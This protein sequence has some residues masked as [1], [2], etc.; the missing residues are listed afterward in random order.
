M[1]SDTSINAALAIRALAFVGDLSMGQPT[2]H[3]LRVAWLASR[4]AECLGASA[5]I[6]V[7]VQQAALLRWSGCTANAPEFSG[8]IDDDVSGRAMI[9]AGDSADIRFQF[10]DSQ[11]RSALQTLAQ[12][13]C[14]VSGEVAGMLSLAGSVERTLRLIFEKF[15]GSGPNRLSGDEVPVDVLIL[16]LASDFEVISRIHGLTRAMSFVRSRGEEA[17]PIRLIRFVIDHGDDW[18][19]TLNRDDEWK[20]DLAAL[21]E[22]GMTRAPLE[23]VADVID[24]KLPWMRGYSRRVS[25]TA[26]QVSALMGMTSSGQALCSRAALIHCMGRAAVPNSVWNIPG[27]LP[28]SAREQIRLTPYWVSRAA[29]QIESLAGEATVASYVSERMDGSGSFRGCKGDRIPIEGQVIAASAAW[30]A[31]NSARPWRAA[32]PVETAKTTLL[33]EAAEGRFNLEVANIL[34]GSSIAAQRPVRAAASVLSEREVQVLQAI[35]LGQT[36]KEVARSLEISPST[37]RTHVESVFRKLG[38]TTRAAATLKA[39]ALGLLNY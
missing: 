10:I 4:I 37:V 14:E 29:S 21:S 24:L 20:S 12:I 34:C 30:V 38:C 32:L 22:G 9:L 16:G 31:L 6:R 36:N 15:D 39:S 19:Q 7:E 8:L 11:I 3:S 17:Y 18:L 35:S 33:K 2:D 25:E 27:T 28:V 13:H 26:R 1:P 5:A 23:L